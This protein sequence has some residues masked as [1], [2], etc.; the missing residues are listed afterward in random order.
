MLPVSL[1]GSA[2]DRVG[3]VSI[4]VAPCQHRLLA[5]RVR[6]APPSVPV[7]EPSVEPFVVPGLNEALPPAGV[8]ELLVDPHGGWAQGT[9][10]RMEG[11]VASFEDEASHGLSVRAVDFHGCCADGCASDLR[12]V[13]H[14]ARRRQ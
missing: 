3:A 4:V 12:G 14:H 5:P 1:S 6:V 10:Q 9:S 11:L 7:P 2:H 13:A 8:S